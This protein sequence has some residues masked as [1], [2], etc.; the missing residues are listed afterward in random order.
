VASLVKRGLKWYVK[1][2]DAQGKQKWKKGYTDKAKTQRLLANKLEDEKT[3][4]QLGILDPQ[5]EVRK[6]ERL[7]PVTEHIA[8]YRDA[9]R[10]RG[11]S[12]N[13]VA[14]TIADIEKCFAHAGVTHA[15][16]LTRGM[17]ERWAVSLTGDTPRTV[18]RRVGSVQAFLRYLRE[19]GTLTDYV[20]HK[21]PKRKVKGTERRKRRALTGEE[22]YR[23]IA[24]APVERKLLYRFALLTG[25]RYAE[26]ASMTP[27]SFNF[28]LRTVT[29]SASDAKNKNKDQ[30]I[31][32]CG[33]LVDELRK[34]CEA[35][36]RD[37]RIFAMPTRRE[38]AALLRDDCKA[39]KVDTTHVDFHALRHTFITRLA[40]AKVHPKI[41][42]ELAR[43]SSIETT[44]TYYT[45]FRQADERNA[46]E[47]LAA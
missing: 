38:A 5:A 42:Q 16:A 13:H 20:L 45:H 22:V 17:V 46:I 12:A 21:F 43:H 7:R 32:L 8:A 24:Q 9:L 29:V 25:F 19:A 10:S 35:R 1:Y 27:A 34:L 15:T 28:N 40:E 26:I 23:L 44:L 30:T 31:P 14:Y 33:L 36:Q 2:Y 41:L 47:S 39:A 6:A 3:D 37:E 18:N 11:S 4:I